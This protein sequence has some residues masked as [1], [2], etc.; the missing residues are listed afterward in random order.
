MIMEKGWKQGKKV[1]VPK[2][3]PAKKELQFYEIDGYHQLEDGFFDLIEPIPEKTDKKNKEEMDVLI[4]PGLIFDRRGYRIGF[5]GG[6]YDRFLSDFPN[7][8]ISLAS[9]FQVRATIPACEYDIPV[10][11]IIT[12]NEILSF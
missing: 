4:V 6:Y 5:G 11:Q 8:T 9:S 10:Q 2:C 1:C 7:Q 3:F 12:E